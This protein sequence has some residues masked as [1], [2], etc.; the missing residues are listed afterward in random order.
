M[1]SAVTLYS[2]VAENESVEVDDRPL[3]ATAVVA[4]ADAAGAA[5]VAAAARGGVRPK[6]AASNGAA[7]VDGAWSI[8][9][10][11]SALG[12]VITT[13]GVLTAT[14]TADAGSI[15]GDIGVVRV[16]SPEA[17]HDGVGGA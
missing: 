10:G 13:A 14:S 16:R 12:V 3:A 6:S 2:F 1:C 4:I 11:A 9:A 8:V 15:A 17:S 7:G 5:G